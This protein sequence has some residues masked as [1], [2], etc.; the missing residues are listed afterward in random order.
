MNTVIKLDNADHEG[1]IIPQWL[2]WTMRMMK[3]GY[4]MMTELKNKDDE[5]GYE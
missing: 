5:G 4:D 2:N 3:V 1:E